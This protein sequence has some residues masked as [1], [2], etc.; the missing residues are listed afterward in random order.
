MITVFLKLLNTNLDNEIVLYSTIIVVTG[1]ITFT[2]LKKTLS[3]SYVETGVQTNIE[4]NY[5]D[6]F[7]PIISDDVSSINT[8][9]PKSSSSTLKALKKKSEVGT[10]TETE[11][12]NNVDFSNSEYIA[13]KVE[14][15]NALDPFSA[16]PW[17][18]ERVLETIDTLGIVNNLFN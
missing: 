14:Q 8:L 18:P 3:K 11:K 13:T 7:D 6:S 15:L 17:T 1:T 16:T 4:G 5:Y 10:Q 9:S 2:L 12:I